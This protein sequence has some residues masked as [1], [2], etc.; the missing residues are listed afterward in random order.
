M[1]VSCVRFL[2][3]FL[4]FWCFLALTFCCSFFPFGLR[5]HYTLGERI[6]R[7]VCC[8]RI[9]VPV[10]IKV[11]A[12]TQPNPWLYPNPNPYPKPQPKRAK[13]GH[14]RGCAAFASNQAIPQLR[15]TIP[16]CTPRYAI[17][18]WK[19]SIRIPSPRLPT[20]IF[21]ILISNFRRLVG[22]SYTEYF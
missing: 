3:W 2:S 22:F 1:Y 11:R 12:K 6:I 20:V 4:A 18:R 16:K 7:L 5:S 14:T 19:T 13:T 9:L 17:F 10:G 15:T 8:S 21:S